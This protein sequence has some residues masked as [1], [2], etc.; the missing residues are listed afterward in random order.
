M[1]PLNLLVLAVSALVLAPYVRGQNWQTRRLYKSMAEKDYVHGYDVMRFLPGVNVFWEFGVTKMPSKIRG[2]PRKDLG[3]VRIWVWNNRPEPLMV[4]P[5]SFRFVAEGIEYARNNA[6]RT[7]LAPIRVVQMPPYSVYVGEMV[8]NVPTGGQYNDD[9]G[10]LYTSPVPDETTTFN[11]WLYWKNP[12]SGDE[13]YASYAKMKAFYVLLSGSKRK[14]SQWSPMFDVEFK[15]LNSKDH[16]A[17][18]PDG[19]RIKPDPAEETIPTQ[20]GD[21]SVEPTLDPIAPETI[22]TV[23]RT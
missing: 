16:L 7:G 18:I 2:A 15:A 5:S 9:Y 8:A 14:K 3:F 11:R 13:L 19:L 21:G 17:T 6:A 23:T 20:G 10:L 1:K 12:L 4:K 22:K